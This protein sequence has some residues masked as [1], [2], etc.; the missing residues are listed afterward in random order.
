ML[1]FP[2]NTS[3]EK[4]SPICQRPGGRSNRLAWQR[5]LQATEWIAVHDITQFAVASLDHPAAKNVTVELGGPEAIGPL[6]AVRCFEDAYG[7]SF[8]LQFV[9]VEALQA[10]EAAADPMQ[11]TFS[12]LMQFIAAGDRIKMSDTYKTFGIRTTSLEKYVSR[13]STPA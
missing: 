3:I 8:E 11:K 13:V 4:R 2:I 1:F 12:V 5:H 10:Q 6:D 7:C 9:P